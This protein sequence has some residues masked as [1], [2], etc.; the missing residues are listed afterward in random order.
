[1]SP[2]TY[3]KATHFIGNYQYVTNDRT[4]RVEG[5]YK[6]Y[7]NL[8]TQ[9]ATDIPFVNNYFNEGTGY[10]KGIDVFFRDKKTIK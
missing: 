3:E 10:A 5:Y 6:D 8:V 4:F 7:D 2:L 1:M 9:E